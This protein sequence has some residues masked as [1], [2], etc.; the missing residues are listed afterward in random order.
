[1]PALEL[2]YESRR[3]WWHRWGDRVVRAGIVAT[4]HAVAMGATLVL[5]I[6]LPLAI[7][8]VAYLILFITAIIENSDLGEILV[9]PALWILI[10]VL[11]GIGSV[12]AI[13]AG[14]TVDAIRRPLR[15][16]L[17]GAADHAVPGQLSRGHDQRPGRP[18]GHGGAT[19][20]PGV[21]RVPNGVVLRV[22]VATGLRRRHP[23]SREVVYRRPLPP[24]AVPPPP[25]PQPRSA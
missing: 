4:S 14:I 25:Q 15:F 23:A 20:G 7:V 1:M 16:P 19:G 10:V 5:L 12:V 9:L 3:P 18:R 11:G 22:L 2:A 6:A 24:V 21:G 8:T 13:L 17:S